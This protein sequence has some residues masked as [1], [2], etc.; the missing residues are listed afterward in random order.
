MQT[1]NKQLENIKTAVLDTLEAGTTGDLHAKLLPENDQS[2]EE[3]NKKVDSLKHEIAQLEKQLEK[4][5]TAID[6]SAY[7]AK[8]VDNT[9]R[10]WV[11]NWSRAE[12]RAK[13]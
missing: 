1:K 6:N 3:R 2:E 4:G 12:D 7:N 5:N 10:K 11:L 9:Y 8:S 13:Q